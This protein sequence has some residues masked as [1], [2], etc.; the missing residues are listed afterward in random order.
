MKAM[1][2]YGLDG[3]LVVHG[4]LRVSGGRR[5]REGG[6]VRADEA[7]RPLGCVREE[8]S[9]PQE[10]LRTAPREQQAPEMGPMGTTATNSS[11]AGKRRVRGAPSTRRGSGRAIAMV[12]A[13]TFIGT[14]RNVGEEPESAERPRSARDQTPQSTEPG[15]RG[16]AGGLVEGKG[17]GGDGAEVRKSA[18]MLADTAAERA[19]ETA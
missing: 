11:S 12:R 10:T 18:R 15:T 9:H 19:V 8:D 13:K 7:V 3:L 17:G 4:Q 2:A 14:A 5:G 1:R 16:D 6:A